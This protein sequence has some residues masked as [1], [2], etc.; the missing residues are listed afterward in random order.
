MS[1]D[2]K[3]KR[4]LNKELA[5]TREEHK[6]LLAKVEKTRAKLEKRKRKLQRLEATIADLERRTVDPSK[7]R[8]GQAMANDA[9]LRRA[10]L[11]VNPDSGKSKTDNSKRLVEIIGSLRA[12]GI[13]AGIDLKTSG[14]AAR[15]LAKEAVESGEELVIV[16][17]GDG[18]IEEVA[19]Q[20]VNT[21]TSLGIIP[22]GTMNNVARS[23][24]IP[25]TIDDACA[26][27]GMGTTRQIDVGRVVANAD[28]EV[29]YF[30][31]AA[32]IGLSAIIIPSG[33]ALEKQRWG[34]IPV[35]L[36]KLFDT[37]P[38]AIEVELDDG[39]VIQA[40][41]QMVTVSNAPLTGKNLMVAPDAKMDD[42]ELDIAIYDGMGKTDLMRY[43]AST[44]NGARPQDPHVKFYRGHGVR[45]RA[46]Q[47]LEASSDKDVIGAKRDFEIEVVPHALSV[48]VGKGIGLSLPVEAVP[49]TP[50][51]SGEQ[52]NETQN[53]NGNGNGN[54]QFKQTENAH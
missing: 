47:A 45:I 24:G 6:I 40:Y 30:L 19:S 32:G 31:E 9:N 12:H 28:P 38:E 36:G 42:G 33:H 39:R 18:T 3:G 41:S 2:E 4:K 48:I 46:S 34:A 27:I 10:R 15:E 11:I 14:R 21:K 43:F 52:K 22:V 7:K 51:L 1:L 44:G 5:R 25:L 26:L 13:V 17:G 50:P 23:L 53:D 49:S 37:K 35:A 29:E 16:A 20:L 54:G 8:L